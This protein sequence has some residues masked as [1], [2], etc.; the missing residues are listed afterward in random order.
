MFAPG[1]GHPP[2]PSGPGC[3]REPAE[4]SLT[5]VYFLMNIFNR[6][7]YSHG[8]SISRTGL[9]VDNSLSHNTQGC[10]KDPFEV[11]QM[12]LVMEQGCQY[13]ILTKIYATSY[14]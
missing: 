13:I 11:H 9:G 8:G 5:M 7:V 2:I 4:G 3:I 12:C 10:R 6:Q 14:V 1:H